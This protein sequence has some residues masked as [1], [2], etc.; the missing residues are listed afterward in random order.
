[1]TP[2]ERE[3]RFKY[4]PPDEK[5]RALHDDVRAMML[6]FVQEMDARLGGESRE[7]SLFYTALEEASFWAHAHIARNIG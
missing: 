3:R 1:M 5:T 6:S 7:V 4:H 2:Q